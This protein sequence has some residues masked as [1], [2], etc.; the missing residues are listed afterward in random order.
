MREM[1]ISRC[2]PSDEVEDLQRVTTRVFSVM[3]DPFG[4]DDK[5]RVL[6]RNA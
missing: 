1:T 4:A 6:P 2:K 5:G 3:L